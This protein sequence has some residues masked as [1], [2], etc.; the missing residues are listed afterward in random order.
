MDRYQLAREIAKLTHE[1]TGLVRE[2]LTIAHDLLLKTAD[3]P[4]TDKQVERLPKGGQLNDATCPG[5]L[6]K[7]TARSGIV[8]YIRRQAKGKDKLYRIGTWPETNAE[9]ARKLWQSIK[10]GEIALGAAN[11]LAKHKRMQAATGPVLLSAAVRSYADFADKHR[12]RSTARLAAC[13]AP[14]P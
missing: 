11:A 6:A 8:W 12:S 7:R 1:A 3:Q 14:S 10:A 4:L 9:S 13:V 5:L 2:H